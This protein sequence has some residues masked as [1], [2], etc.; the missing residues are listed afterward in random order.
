[1]QNTHPT[2]LPAKTPK[3]VKLT[4]VNMPQPT[5]AQSTNKEDRLLL[6]IYAPNEHQFK[7]VLAAALSL[8]CYGCIYADTVV[9]VVIVNLGSYM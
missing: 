1:M 8:D 5:Q 9:I 3:R 6:A 7:S 2:E 4:K